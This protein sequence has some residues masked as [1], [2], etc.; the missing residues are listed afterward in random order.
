MLLE[1]EMQH[2]TTKSIA[3]NRD[4]RNI[5]DERKPRKAYHMRNWFHHVLMNHAFKYL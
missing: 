5:F 4:E 2:V 3:E 1:S